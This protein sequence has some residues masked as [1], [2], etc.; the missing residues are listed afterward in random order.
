MPAMMVMMAPVMM[1][2]PPMV[3]MPAMVPPPMMV[4]MVVPAMTPPPM[5]MMVM[6]AVHLLHEPFF[7]DADRCGGLWRE[8]RSGCRRQEG[9]RS[10]RRCAKGQFHEH[11]STSPC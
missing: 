10:Q 7:L 11:P 6:P 3:M 1:V 2:P 4:M 8:R 5:V 9:N